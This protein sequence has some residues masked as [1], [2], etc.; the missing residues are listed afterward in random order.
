MA[1]YL[2]VFLT[3]LVVG[4]N[5]GPYPL[6]RPNEAL[7]GLFALVIIVRW[8]VRVRTG[9]REWPKL[10]HRLSLIALGATSSIVPL[11]MMVAAAA[12]HR[13]R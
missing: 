3:P 2:L 12:G 7:M 11:I 10:D 13:D 8:I 6:V 5:V 9:D 1:A 4:V